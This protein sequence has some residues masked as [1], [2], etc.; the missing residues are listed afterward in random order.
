[1]PV[2]DGSSI[3]HNVPPN[4]VWWDGDRWV[5]PD[6][7][8]QESSSRSSADTSGQNL[9]ASDDGEDVGGSGCG[10]AAPTSATYARSQDVAEGSSSAEDRIG[11][12]AADRISLGD[13]C[14][15]SSQSLP[16]LRKDG[17]ITN[18]G[19]AGHPENCKPCAFYCFSLRG[20]RNGAECA[21]CHLFH[22]SKLRQRREDW[23]KSQCEKREKQR[24]DQRS[25]SALA[26]REAEA[27]AE[28]APP[29]PVP[30]PALKQTMRTDLAEVAALS[31][32]QGARAPRPMPEGNVPV[33]AA[34]PL[35]VASEMAGWCNAGT[36]AAAL[37]DIGG[38]AAISRGVPNRAQRQPQRYPP[39]PAGVDAGLSGPVNVFTY[40][41]NTA[42]IGVGQT[43]ELLPPVHIVSAGMVFAV[44]PDLPMGLMLDERM[45]LVHGKA[46]E[47]TPGMVKYYIMACEPGDSSLSVKMSVVELGVMDTHAPSRKA[48]HVCELKR[49]NAEPQTSRSA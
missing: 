4:S 12:V 8:R 33:A 28:V 1:M 14:S 25:Q 13:G 20:C 21:Y 29:A 27:S 9:S 36:P 10:S 5:N 40:T 30:A 34:A 37:V 19:S 18:S 2:P 22:E 16:T 42:V 23:K 48:K 44:S 49:A 45:G 35:P 24:R 38:G 6:G 46:Q 3:R 11:G 43:I 47:A 39:P 26:E 15:E 31:R 17:P 41:P 7:R 32:N